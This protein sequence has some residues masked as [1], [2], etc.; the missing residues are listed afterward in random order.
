M[1]QSRFTQGLIQKQSVVVNLSAKVSLSGS[2]PWPMH[3]QLYD[4]QTITV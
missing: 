2:R 3:L 1:T 4:Q